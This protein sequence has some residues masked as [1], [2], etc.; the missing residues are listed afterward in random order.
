MFSPLEISVLVIEELLFHIRYHSNARCAAIR[1]LGASPT[2]HAR[3]SST[4]ET[5]DEICMNVP[6]AMLM[7]TIRQY[8]EGWYGEFVTTNL[9]IQDGH[10]LSAR[11]PRPRNES[12]L[13]GARASR[14][15]DSGQR[16]DRGT[17]SG[18]EAVANYVS[19]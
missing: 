4:E 16:Q 17:L 5:L 6:N 3:G 10:L 2:P 8:Y 12:A 14:R 1:R 18:V 15:K 9:N 19:M 13:R 7:E 11:R